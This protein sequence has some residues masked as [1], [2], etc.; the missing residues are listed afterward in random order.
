[1]SR[2]LLLILLFLALGALLVFAALEQRVT[3]VVAKGPDPTSI[4]QYLALATS[5]VSLV[6]AI[7]G[8]LRSTGK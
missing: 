1:M 4:A 5:V 7:V 8:L 2:K 3:G 6:T